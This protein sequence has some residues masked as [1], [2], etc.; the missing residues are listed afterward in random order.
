MNEGV[1]NIL[2]SSIAAGAGGDLPNI[3]ST[4]MFHI[5]TL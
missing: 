5:H 3:L 4:S 1:G 2:L